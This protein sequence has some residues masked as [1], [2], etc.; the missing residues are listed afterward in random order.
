[1]PE[2]VAGERPRLSILERLSWRLFTTHFLIIV[3]AAGVPAVYLFFFFEAEVSDLLTREVRR[4]AGALAIALQEEALDLPEL[5]ERL[6]RMRH[7]TGLRLTLVDRQGVVLVET[8]EE[9]AAQGLTNHADRPEIG[10]ALSEGEGV[11]RRLSATVGLPYVYAAHRIEF[12]GSE[13]LIL[14]AATPWAPVESRLFGM[15]RALLLAFLLATLSGG[16]L[17]WL[18]ARRLTAPIAG[19]ASVA[20]RLAAEDYNARVPATAGGELRALAEAIE[21]L[22]IQVRDKVR[23]LEEEKQLLLTI[24]EAMTEGVLVVDA[25]SRLLMANSRSLDLLGVS[26]MW[27]PP[28]VENRL[29]LE[30]TRHPRIN[31]LVEEVLRSGEPV[32]AEASLHLRSARH[33]AVSCAPL[34][35]G[36]AVR[37]AVMALYDLTQVRQLERVR[38][39]FVANVSHELRTPVAAIGGWAETLASDDED[40]PPGVRRNL[41]RILTHARRLAALV[42]DLLVLARVESIGIE[43]EFVEVDL[44]VVLEDT[45]GSLRER[46]E[47]RGHQVERS[48]APEAR[49]F[50]TE[51]RS[52]EYVLRN[53]IENA[54]K[55]TPAEGRIRIVVDLDPEGLLR[56]EVS[57][58]GVGIEERHLPRIFER[59]YRVDRGRSRE[60]GGTGLGLAIVKHFA[61]A[62]GGEV[63]VTSSVGE[64]STFTLIL[65]RR[66][67]AARP[68]AR[69]LRENF[70]EDSPG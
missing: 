13:P 61:T 3:L 54:V 62:L 43:D 49:L 69:G 21:V 57:D 63:R 67:A 27:T 29:L 60:V 10:G 50:R 9:L 58:T 51:P 28:E 30:V 36:A 23:Q 37:G 6:H 48:V 4:T 22:Q 40:V 41:L 11:D 32:R 70:S 65:P 17:S 31:A 15:R 64:G 2:S 12:D 68:G 55:Y 56:V 44:A 25:S 53:L 59:F 18:V 46:I 5:E 35:E 1:M 38:Q 16:L 34:R 45:L 33:L 26:D 66:S 20:K 47:A 52:L 14:R 8:H 39:D 24:V 7:E 42:D 19:L